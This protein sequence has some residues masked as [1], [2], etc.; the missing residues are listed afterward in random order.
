VNILFRIFE[1]VYAV[2]IGGTNA[3][4][5]IIDSKGESRKITT[6]KT[7]YRCKPQRLFKKIFSQCEG[8]PVCLSVAGIV[9]NK[10][11]K[12][13]PNLYYFR[14][15]NLKKY[16]FA[17]IENDANAS[18]FG[19]WYWERKNKKCLITLTLG[20]GAGGGVVYHGK[21]FKGKG[22]GCEIGHG[23]MNFEGGKCNCGSYGCIENYVSSHY[24]FRV[25]G[26]SPVDAFILA[27]TNKNTREK[28][29]EYGKFLG[30][31]IA[32]LSNIFAPDCVVLTGGITFAKKYFDSVMRKEYR[33]RVMK[34]LSME[35]QYSKH[36]LE[37][38]LLG[39]SA[40]YFS[41]K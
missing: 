26:K 16:N 17:V 20:S 15:I 11:I 23:V 3:K 22:D 39:V 31:A 4:C 8:L 33:K 12:E 9:E 5:S 25:L 27:K 30:I 1:E 34:S 24:F 19:E 29:R 14:N 13:N 18:A 32:S 35:I 40:L 41:K 38:A 2:D 37:S 28:F 10:F 36:P 7:G 6:L 21:I